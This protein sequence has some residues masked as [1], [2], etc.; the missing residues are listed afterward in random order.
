MLWTWKV[1]LL[2]FSEHLFESYLKGQV[3][4]SRLFVVVFI[5]FSDGS[6]LAAA[7]QE[8]NLKVDLR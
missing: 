4:A 3:D 1:I 2:N 5:G 6:G 7:L 8:L